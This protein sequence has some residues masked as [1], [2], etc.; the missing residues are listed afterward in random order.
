MNRALLSEAYSLPTARYITQ[1]TGRID[2]TEILCTHMGATS[3]SNATSKKP[4]IGTIAFNP[5]TAL[6]LYNR[7]SKEA[8]VMHLPEL[9]SED[10]EKAFTMICQNGSDHID[11]H[12]FG[13]P[14]NAER[15]PEQNSEEIARLNGLV[16]K[17]KDLPN[18]RL[19][20]FDV[21]DKPKPWNV[22]IDTR[23]GKL[24]RGS[25]L[26]SNF[27]EA[28]ADIS[29]GTKGLAADWPLSFKD[30]DGTA[31]EQQQSLRL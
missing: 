14:F 23:T 12:L 31:V 16:A 29:T 3:I 4:V 10:V 6:I 26:F 24:I 18:C 22:A 21:Y 7:K 1:Q 2:P 27:A 11:V 20:T 19:A 17:L 15:T 30:F 13:A 28:K 5:C 8:V 25:E 9:S